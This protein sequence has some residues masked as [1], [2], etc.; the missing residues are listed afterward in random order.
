MDR[1]LLLLEHIGGLQLLD[2][3]DNS[4]DVEGLMG[5]S[6][7]LDEWM[8]LDSLV[9]EDVIGDMISKILAFYDFIMTALLR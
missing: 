7:P 3:K 6:I 9:D 5:L 2:V 4:D 8:R 1:S